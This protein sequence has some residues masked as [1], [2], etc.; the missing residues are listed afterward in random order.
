METYSISIFWIPLIVVALCWI[1][2]GLTAIVDRQMSAILTFVSAGN[3][4]VSY[5]CLF[6]YGYLFC[7][8]LALSSYT[9]NILDYG[10]IDMDIWYR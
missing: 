10:T 9:Y 5:Y 8:S 3:Y 2:A 7:S 6:H 4:L 1:G